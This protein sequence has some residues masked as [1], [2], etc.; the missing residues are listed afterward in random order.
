MWEGR[1]PGVGCL[2]CWVLGAG[3]WELGA[4]SRNRQEQEAATLL[5]DFDSRARNLRTLTCSAG[6]RRK[7]VDRGT[8]SPVVPAHLRACNVR[9]RYAAGHWYWKLVQTTGR[10][11][12]PVW[13]SA[14]CH[15]DIRDPWLQVLLRTEWPPADRTPRV[16]VTV[17][18]RSCHSCGGC[19]ACA[20]APV[21]QKY[22]LGIVQA[23][24]RKCVNVCVCLP[25]KPRPRKPSHLQ[26]GETHGNVP[27][28]TQAKRCVVCVR[29]SRWASD[30]LSGSLEQGCVACYGYSSPR[31]PL[32]VPGPRPGTEPDLCQPRVPPLLACPFTASPSA[33]APASA[34]P[35]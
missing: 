5:A 2:G 4:G 29:Q 28:E 7:T 9:S 15:R 13:R 19:C 31:L 35:R 14:L 10:S 32:P 16:D 17:G 20:C 3:S 12:A 25:R 34:C 6:A 11:R 23:G 18:A 30:A 21:P 8:L 1:R 26:L 33:S 27:T 22:S 24:A